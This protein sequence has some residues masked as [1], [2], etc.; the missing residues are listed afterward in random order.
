MEKR[1]LF[2]LL[3]ACTCI[4]IPVPAQVVLRGTVVSAGTQEPL[5]FV[6]IGI[7][8]KNTGTLSAENGTFLLQLKAGQESDT[9][10]FSL[11][12]Y[13]EL[14]L[15]VKAILDG[16]QVIFGL[17][18]NVRELK[19]VTVS[20]ENTTQRRFGIKKNSLINFGDASLQQNDIFE[21]A[22]LIR[23]PPSSSKITSAHLFIV[24][25]KSDSVTFRINFYRLVNGRPAGRL[26]EKSI[27]HTCRAQ[28]GWLTVDLVP[29]D[30][31]LS[32]DVVLGIEFIPGEKNKPL[33]YGLKIGGTSK[34]FLRTSSLGEWTVPPAHYRMYLTA[35]VNGAAKRPAGDEE[36]DTPPTLRLF[37]KAV[38]DSF[39]V[40]VAL[41]AGYRAK[42]ANSLSVVY[43]L[44]ANMYFDALAVFLK[45]QK[46]RNKILVGIGYRDAAEMD[47]LRNR[48]YTVPGNDGSS[49]CGGGSRF[50]SFINE[51]LIPCIGK[52]YGTEKS[53]RTLM[54][55][56]L[57]GYF[58]I[59]ALQQDLAGRSQA[60]NN[61]VA[62]SPSLEYHQGWLNRQLGSMQAVS[63][64]A[65]RQVFVCFEGKIDQEDVS[66]K[67]REHYQELV[68]ILSGSTFSSVRLQQRLYAD[69][70]HMETAL[71]EFFKALR[72]IK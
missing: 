70:G 17:R 29:H 67:G 52:K 65:G 59:Y 6:N 22:Q 46:I 4:Q 14:S 66:E 34:S 26:V 1:R 54:G 53:S 30:L 35:L 28:E 33:H 27:L 31:C 61:Y 32:G 10:T 36:T 45:E 18:A 23:L 41:P 19:T 64:T 40:F 21:I 63:G 62:P 9:L 15:P 48:D 44:D 43:L 8:R 2:I 58:T 39:S 60:F 55:H 12:G 47:S 42:K 5:S 68:R 7:R 16:S 49:L 11:V 50:L 72:E 56:S 69:F 38:N 37:S 57:G 20:S 25:A 24:K 13:K 71:P 3:L 51:E